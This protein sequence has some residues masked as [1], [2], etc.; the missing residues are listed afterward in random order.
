[1][2]SKFIGRYPSAGLL[3]YLMTV[4]SLYHAPDLCPAHPA[5]PLIR[6]MAAGSPPPHGQ[7]K[8]GSQAG[9]DVIS[10][11]LWC[12]AIADAMGIRNLT[13]IAGAGTSSCEVRNG[14]RVISLNR[15][16]PVVVLHELAHCLFGPSEA[17]AQAWAIRQVAEAT[18][19]SP[20]LGSYHPIF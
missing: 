16:E 4:D 5:V 9:A 20:V 13:V 8:L 19:L 12:R 14:V 15:P 3:R 6:Q 11:A 2:P 1:M 17:T 10:S 18:G 7:V